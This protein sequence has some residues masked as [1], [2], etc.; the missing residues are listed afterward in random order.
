MMNERYGTHAGHHDRG[1]LQLID[2]AVRWWGAHR[3]WPANEPVRITE[4]PCPDCRR[5]G[6]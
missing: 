6:G 1:M 2:E 4:R 3:G 5:V